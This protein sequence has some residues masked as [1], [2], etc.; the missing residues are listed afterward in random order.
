[1]GSTGG[2]ILEWDRWG[3]KDLYG[4]PANI[5]FGPN[6]MLLTPS[7]MA[8]TPNPFVWIYSRSNGPVHSH[9]C[10]TMRYVTIKGA[11]SIARIGLGDRWPHPIF[12]L[13]YFPTIK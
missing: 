6:P 9:W 10:Q 1:M 4:T 2:P 3:L 8:N 12:S 13:D 5:K 11:L 7:S